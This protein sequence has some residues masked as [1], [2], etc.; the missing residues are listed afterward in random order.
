MNF[1]H[2]CI[3]YHLQSF[4]YD[5]FI[6]LKSFWAK[7]SKKYKWPECSKMQGGKNHYEMYSAPILSIFFGHRCWRETAKNLVRDR[8]INALVVFWQ[9]Q[10]SS[11]HGIQDRNFSHHVTFI[12]DTHIF[13]ICAISYFLF[14][15]KCTFVGLIQNPKV[16]TLY[17][18][19][20]GNLEIFTK[21]LISDEKCPIYERKQWQM[22]H[23][24]FRWAVNVVAKT[25]R[26]GLN[27]AKR[28]Q[29]SP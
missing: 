4:Y 29:M 1:S 17:G 9:L 28:Q 26:R 10:S 23:N 6:T 24:I 7:S 5:L 22:G 2:H 20:A 21:F 18:E 15:C 3:F 13:I 14:L 16:K 25:I 11:M 27:N 19:K 8:R 12:Y